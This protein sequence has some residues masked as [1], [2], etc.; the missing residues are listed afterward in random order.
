MQ[1]SLSTNISKGALPSW[2]HKALLF[3]HWAW[4]ELEQR[5]I[6][7]QCTELCYELLVT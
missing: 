5:I 4:V 3:L 2:A 1:H 6:V 7:I